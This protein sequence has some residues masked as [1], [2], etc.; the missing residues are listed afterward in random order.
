[1]LLLVVY[2]LVYLLTIDKYF[3]SIIKPLS[4]IVAIGLD[5]FVVFLLL[6]SKRL[7]LRLTIWRLLLLIYL[8]FFLTYHFNI[9]ILIFF[10]IVSSFRNLIN[11]INYFFIK[12][13]FPLFLIYAPNAFTIWTKSSFSFLKEGWWSSNTFIF[14]PQPWFYFCREIPFWRLLLLILLRTFSLELAITSR[15]LFA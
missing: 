14:I 4:W 5:L 13:K 10:F 1:M 2:I 6:S 12:T 11:I 7:P 15:Q 8:I 3:L 9:A